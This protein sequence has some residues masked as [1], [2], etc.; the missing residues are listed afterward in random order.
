MPQLSEYIKKLKNENKK[1]FLL[2]NSCYD[3]INDACHYLFEDVISD[4]GVK[5]WTEVFD[6]TFCEARKPKWFSSSSKF[7]KLNFNQLKYSTPRELSQL[8]FKPI[9]SLEK[10]GVY[11]GGSLKEFHILTGLRNDQVIY[12]GDNVG[13]DL[14][15]PSK[16]GQWKTVAIIKELEREIQVNNDTDFR[17]NL[18]YLLDL[19]HLW[20]DG[21]HLREENDDEIN[22]ALS[23][24]SNER[25]MY[26]D[27]IKRQY[28]EKFGSIFRTHSTRTLFFHRLA[29]YSDLYTSK[30]TNMLEY[31]LYYKFGAR[32][33]FYD[34]EPVL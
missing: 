16:T 32:R 17:K 26:R 24:L 7:R 10:H 23:E 13:S 6:W 27:L 30:V 3:Y 21:Q 34:H 33:Q 18:S 20:F 31:P 12:F 25:N 2:T 4:L 14:I 29:R 28:N 19:E 11:I 15:G 5:H 8:T 1:I 22:N 9:E